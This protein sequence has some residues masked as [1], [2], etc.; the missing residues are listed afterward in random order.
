MLFSLLLSLGEYQLTPLYNVFVVERNGLGLCHKHVEVA[1]LDELVREKDLFLTYEL[2]V[3]VSRL[4]VYKEI[5]HLDSPQLLVEEGEE[6]VLGVTDKIVFFHLFTPGHDV[7]SQ[8]KGV[9]L[10][11]VIR[12]HVVLVCLRWVDLLSP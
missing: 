9:A 12:I 4:A 1:F 8:S 3:D 7:R 2:D 11:T 5:L 6:R 10:V